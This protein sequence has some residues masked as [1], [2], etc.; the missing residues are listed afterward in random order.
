MQADSAVAPETQLGTSHLGSRKQINCA[1]GAS[2]AAGAKGAKGAKGAAGGAGAAE[3]A[4]AADAADAAGAAEAAGAAS[5]AGTAGSAGTA[6]VA[7]APDATDAP[8]TAPPVDAPIVQDKHPHELQYGHGATIGLGLTP[9]L[10]ASGGSAGDAEAN[11]STQK[12]TDKR[13]CEPTTV[14]V[15]RSVNRTRGISADGGPRS[16][17]Q[18]SR[19]RPVQAGQHIATGTRDLYLQR[20]RSIEGLS[21]PGTA[22]KVRTAVGLLATTSFPKDVLTSTKSSCERWQPSSSMPRHAIGGYDH[23]PSSFAWAPRLPASPQNVSCWELNVGAA[24]SRYGGYSGAY[25]GDRPG[26]GAWR[27]QRGVLE[28]GRRVLATREARL[29]SPDAKL[30]LGSAAAN[31]VTMHRQQAA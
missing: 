5:A 20:S 15:E 12:A 31:G 17:A 4:D 21:S 24:P 3:A 29:V 27:P 30:Y 19:L 11:R 13:P 1:G 23:P 26:S 2:E 6:D 8:D 10:T 25:T 22:R 7:D 14:D 9:L 16:P 18:V 28:E